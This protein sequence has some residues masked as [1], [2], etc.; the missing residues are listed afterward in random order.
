MSERLTREMREEIEVRMREGVEEGEGWTIE[1]IKK[2]LHLSKLVSEESTDI[3]IPV[4]RCKGSECL[5][6]ALMSYSE[7]HDEIIF[8]PEIIFDTYE[9]DIVPNCPE[10]SLRKYIRELL[11][12]EYDH[13]KQRNQIVETKAW[14]EE[15]IKTG[16]MEKKCASVAVKYACEYKAHR[17]NPEC[18]KKITRKRLKGLELAVEIDSSM[19]PFDI[20]LSYT[21]EEI[22]R[23]FPP[24]IAH[25]LI[26][27]QGC[28][29]KWDLADLST[30]S[31]K[32]LT[33]CI[34]DK[35]NYSPTCR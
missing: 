10:I 9:E 33:Q 7:E 22:K 13:A 17:A 34:Y 20:S 28:Y 26:G 12:H 31:F 32:G 4:R 35:M 30:V 16:R 19:T 18:S 21:P 1:R 15:N 23:L 29:A 3:P 8:N 24:H 27:L 25:V 11:L 5:R 2:E 6:F 14:V